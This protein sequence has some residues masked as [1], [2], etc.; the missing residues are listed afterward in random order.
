MKKEADALCSAKQF[1]ADAFFQLIA[2]R[3]ITHV[4]CSC[5]WYFVVWLCSREMC[6][7]SEVLFFL[8][9]IIVSC[10]RCPCSQAAGQMQQ[11]EEERIS[12]MKDALNRYNSHLSVVGPKLVKVRFAFY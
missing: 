8:C 9:L 11:L 5:C 3:L 7:P 6:R 1:F 2:I 4:V 10:C 12:A